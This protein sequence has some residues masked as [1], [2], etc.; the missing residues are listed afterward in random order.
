MRHGTQQ[1]KTAQSLAHTASTAIPGSPSYMAPKCLLQK[2]QA[3]T[4]SDV[5]KQQLNP[6]ACTLL[7]LFTERNCWEYLLNE[8]KP[9]S[10][11]TCGDSSY[12]VEFFIAAVERKKSARVL[13][14]PSNMIEA[15]LQYI[16]A[17]C[18][19]YDIAQRPRTID[20]VN[21]LSAT[22]AISK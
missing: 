20:I 6:L 16:L 3:T 4:Q 8:N 11:E 17:H 19:E 9:A 15:S 2:K 5:C 1:V 10:G 12:D 14:L 21:A 7:E 18:F 22:L 13:G